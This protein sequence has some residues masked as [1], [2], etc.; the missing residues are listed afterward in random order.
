MTYIF[1]LD[2]SLESNKDRIRESPE[3]TRQATHL[4]LGGEVVNN[5]KELPNLF[6]GLALDHVSNGL[7]SDIAT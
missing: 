6:R 3:T 2:L 5:V 1:L 4:F 7:A